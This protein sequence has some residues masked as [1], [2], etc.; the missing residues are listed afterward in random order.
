MSDW[1]GVD[2]EGDE[3]ARYLEVRASKEKQF[4]RHPVPSPSIRLENMV[5]EIYLG[6]QPSRYCDSFAIGTSADCGKEWGTPR[7]R[8]KNRAAE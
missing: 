1:L 6:I 3:L 5:S 8:R 2:L 7:K 4:P